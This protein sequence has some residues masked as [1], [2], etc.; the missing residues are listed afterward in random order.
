MILRKPVYFDS[1]HCIG[2]ACKD[3]CCAGWEV[4]IDEESAAGYHD[5]DGE[6]GER[7]KA[8]ITETEEEIYFNLRED[9]RCPFLNEDNLCDLILHLGEDS[10]CDICREHPRHY[11][12]FGRY[13]E[14]GLGLCCEEAGRLIFSSPEKI[15]YI[16][17]SD[18]GSRISDDGLQARTGMQAGDE[19]Q[20]RTEMKAEAEMQGEQ[21]MQSAD[22]EMQELKDGE[23]IE[24]ML[25]ARRTAFS[26]I[27][28]RHIPLSERLI[29]LLQYAE[30]LQ[31]SLDIDDYEAFTQSVQIYENQEACYQAWMQVKTMLGEQKSGSEAV[32]YLHDLLDIY[33]GL[34]SLDG[35]FNER[36]RELHGYVGDEKALEAFRQGYPQAEAYEYEHFSM[37]LIYRYFMQTLF[38]GDLSGK[39][40]FVVISVI[41]LRLM[42]VQTANERKAGMKEDDVVFSLQDRIENAKQYSK[43]VEYCTD[44]MDALGSLCWEE[45]CMSTEALIMMLE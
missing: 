26:I 20:A 18:D 8:N 13:T 15:T 23:Y 30:E 34:E 5:I 3:T 21:D 44:N 9:K 45:E 32:V 39:M 29:L 41:I 6:I 17:M 24:L 38:D 37:Y 33:A 28:N 27:Q 2:S 42:D 43:E 40:K 4:E 1:F 19:M 16:E 22:E 35:S 7:L 25:K 31:E 14:V 11:E 10:L 36:M 12:W